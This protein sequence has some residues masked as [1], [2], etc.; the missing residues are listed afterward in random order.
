MKKRVIVHLSGGLGNQMFQY[1]A[2]A[3][4][5]KKTDAKLYVNLNWF[6]NP[7]FKHRSNS[8]YESK[9]KVELDNFGV[10]DRNTLDRFP[11]FRDGR[12]ERMVA[13][14][15]TPFNKFFGVLDEKAIENSEWVDTRTT[16]RL[17]GFFMSPKYFFQINPMEY[18]S[19]LSSGY[20][21]WGVELKE[22]IENSGSIGVHVRLGDYV[23]LGDKVIPSEDYFLNAIK[24]LK[25]NLGE[26]SQVYLFTDDYSGLQSKFPRLA[27]IGKV[28]DPPKEISAA[29][30]L[31]LLSRCKNF[32]SSNSTFSW[33]A[34]RLS[35]C[36][37]SAIVRPSYFYTDFPEIDTNSDLWHPD[38]MSLNPISG[39]E[40]LK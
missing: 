24:K 17:F 11:T 38:S 40:V 30:N 21:T 19:R 9:R 34:A 26:D 7:T 16:S 2:G 33:W 13:K 37:P 10:L 22:Q 14:E 23:H 32:V 5:A 4:I 20:S 8:A 1:M 6:K 39:I 29:E 36:N 3:S 27:S 15:F 31:L 28:I 35:E 12:M 18:F 25:S